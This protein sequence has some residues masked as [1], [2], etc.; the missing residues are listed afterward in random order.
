MQPGELYQLQ[1]AKN[2]E[3]CEMVLKA[4]EKA[5]KWTFS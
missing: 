5:N 1:F 2:N 4:L 3:E